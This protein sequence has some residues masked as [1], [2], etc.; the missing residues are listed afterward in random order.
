MITAAAVN[1]STANTNKQ[2]KLTA[3]EVIAAHS[4]SPHR[5]ARAARP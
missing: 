2:Q 5:A 3:K 4:A 1:Q